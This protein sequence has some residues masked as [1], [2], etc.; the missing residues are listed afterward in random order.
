VRAGY[1]HSG[2]PIPADQTFFNILAP[3]VISDH[4]SVGASYRVTSR[5]ELSFAY[6]YAVKQTVQGNGSIPA[7]FAGGN[8]NIF[9]SENILSLAYG[10]KL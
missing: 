5:G 10:W 4:A 7:N 6:T 3:G 1:S 9:L 2:Q 8:A